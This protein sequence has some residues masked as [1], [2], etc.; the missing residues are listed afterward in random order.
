[1]AFSITEAQYMAV[2]QRLTALENTVNDIIVAMEKFVTL[3]QTNSLLTINAQELQVVR[4][5][6]EALEARVTNIENEPLS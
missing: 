6:V 3:S 5:D 4:T 1:M 2:L